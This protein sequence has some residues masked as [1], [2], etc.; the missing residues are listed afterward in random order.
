MST[1]QEI[2][3]AFA[4]RIERAGYD[5]TNL[6]DIAA[7][8]HI[9]KKTIYVHFDGKRDIYAELVTRQA[10]RDKMR[11]AAAVATLP[12]YVARVEA[13]VTMLL[14]MA[15]DHIKAT[16]REEWLREY[17][18]AADA[19]RQAHGELLRELIAAGMEAGEFATGDAVFAERIVAAMLLDYTR[20]VNEDPSV[21]RDAELVRRIIR[22]LT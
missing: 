18:I 3:E 8:L 21:D 13:H 20:M 11:L 16:G 15:R 22:F 9:S 5:R 2:V 12:T 14:G 6:D 19:F 4:R 7:E 10:A 17:E 1:K